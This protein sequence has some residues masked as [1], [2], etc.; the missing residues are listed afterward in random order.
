VIAANISPRP[1]VFSQK[2]SVWER[3]SRVVPDL[4]DETK[5]VRSRSSCPSSARIARGCV[6]SRTWNQSTPNVRRS[7]SGASDE[8]PIPQRTT[9][10]ISSCSDSAK[11]RM[12]SSC[13]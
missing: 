10:S 8:P 5:N 13:S 3:V 6:V 12:S 11:R 2:N 9:A 1:P 4:D 7:T